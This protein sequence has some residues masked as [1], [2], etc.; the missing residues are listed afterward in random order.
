MM[1]DSMHIGTDTYV[2]FHKKFD[3]GFVSARIMNDSILTIYDSAGIQVNYPVQ[4]WVF[5]ITK[6]STYREVKISGAK[7][8]IKYR[9]WIYGQ[10]S[11]GW[12]CIEGVT[13]LMPDGSERKLIG[14]KW[15]KL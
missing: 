11:G 6:D 7:L 1:S 4:H 5:S 8:P 13:V 12:I 14:E 2:H 10:P 15:V 9:E 3:Q